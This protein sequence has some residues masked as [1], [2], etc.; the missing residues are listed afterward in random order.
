MANLITFTQSK[1]TVIDLGSKELR[2]K[3]YHEFLKGDRGKTRK[4]KIGWDSQA[5][6]LH[7]SVV[8]HLKP[9]Q[10]GQKAM[11]TEGGQS[12]GSQGLKAYTYQDIGLPVS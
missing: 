9:P 2:A 1:Q 12:C 5:H 6:I 4:R 3:I 8:N 11:P 10:N 7:L